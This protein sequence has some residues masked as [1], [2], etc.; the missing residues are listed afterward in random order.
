LDCE[1]GMRAII[2]YQ[3]YSEVDPQLQRLTL[4]LP[5]GSHMQWRMCGCRRGQ[6]RRRVTTSV[7]VEQRFAGCHLLSIVCMG[8]WGR[9]V[10]GPQRWSGEGVRRNVTPGPRGAGSRDVE[11]EI[12]T[13]WEVWGSGLLFFLPCIETKLIISS[14]CKVVSFLKKNY[15]W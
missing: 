2:H 9:L 14:T 11:E 6:S 13:H 7:E 4:Y 12:R 8:R 15:K 5:E 1:G 10:K 3:P